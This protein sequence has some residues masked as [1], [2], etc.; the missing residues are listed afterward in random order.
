[1]HHQNRSSIFIN[2]KATFKNES[3]IARKQIIVKTYYTI[4]ENNNII[5]DYESMQK[6]FNNKLNELIKEYE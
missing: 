6:E 5:I 3:I 2:M 4:N 1:M